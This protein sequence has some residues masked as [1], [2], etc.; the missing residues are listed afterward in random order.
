MRE[1]QD[2]EDPI[3]AAQAEVLDDRVR[4]ER[5]VAMQERDALRLARRARRVDDRREV[6]VHRLRPQPGRVRLGLDQLLQRRRLPD[7]AADADD[8]QQLRRAQ[9]RVCHDVRVA[10][11]ADGDRRAGVLEEERE[12]LLLGR[13]VQRRERRPGAQGAVDRDGR[14]HAV[15]EHDGDAVA[16]ST[17]SCRRPAGE[18]R[19]PHGRAR[20]TLTPPLPVDDGRAI[21][22]ARRAGAQIVGEG[23][24]VH[25]YAFLP[26]M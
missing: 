26:S 15:G 23:P 9:R 1:R 6:D 21:G 4:D 14:L 5:H 24:G 11:V 25:H 3:L 13:R 17:P 2:A 12:L 22:A 8:V 16:A 10:R 7:T 19:R 18:C 20:R